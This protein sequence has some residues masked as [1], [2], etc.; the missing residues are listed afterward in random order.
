MNKLTPK[1]NKESFSMATAFP[2]DLNSDRRLIVLVPANS[3]YMTVARQTWELANTA[4]MNV[5]FI[6]LCKDA[7]QE[8]GLR[9]E[10]IAMSAFVQGG[11]VATDI[12]VEIGTNW[13]NTLEI[14]YRSGDLAVCFAEQ[15]DGILQGSITRMLKTNMNI[16]VHSRLVLSQKKFNSNLL[17]QLI[18][19]SG[20]IGIIIGFFV[21]QVKIAQLPEDWFQSVLFI[22]SFTSEI[23]LI[24]IWNSLFS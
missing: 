17:T 6:G 7:M 16:P 19:W 20:F 14:D 3:D 5:R 15:D 4:G 22:L 2:T 10:L 23:W 24:W 12:K 8:P 9:R 13:M 18:L 1:R 11:R 21:L